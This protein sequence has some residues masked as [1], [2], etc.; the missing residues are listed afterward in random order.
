MSFMKPKVPKVAP[1]TPTV[2]TPQPFDPAPAVA[3]RPLSMTTGN[4]DARAESIITGGGNTAPDLA[5]M[6]T[7][8][9][10]RSLIGG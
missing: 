6:P 10:R 2:L 3:A 1:T 8:R 9:R 4:S 5:Q 7:S